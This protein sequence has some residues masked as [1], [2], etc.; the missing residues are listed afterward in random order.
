MSFTHNRLCV[1]LIHCGNK[2]IA[3]PGESWEKN[4]FYLPM[5][6]FPMAAVLKGKGIDVEIISMDLEGGSIED[7]L[8][9]STLDA[10]GMDCHWVNQSSAVLDL[11]ALIKKIKPGVFIFLGGYSASFFSHEIL[12]NYSAVDA[13]IKGDGEVPIAELCDVL[14]KRTQGA[15]NLDN[16]RNLSWKNDRGEIVSNDISYVAAPEQ[17][18]TLDFAEISLLRNWKYYRDLSKFWTK[19]TPLDQFPVFFL[20][21][22]R[23][24]CYNC[25]FCGGNSRAQECIGNRRG[26][27]VRSIDSVIATIEKAVSYGYGMIYHSLEFEGSDRWYSELFRRIKKENIVK[28]HAYGCWGVPSKFLIDELSEC[29]E[30]AIIEVSPETA[31]LELR[32]KNKDRRI[33]YSNE[34]LEECLDYIKTKPNVKI[35]L[36]FG[37]FLPFETEESVFTTLNYI[38]TLL[39]KY[40][41]VAEVIYS[42]LSTDPASLLFLDPGKYDVAISVRCIGDYIDALKENNIERIKESQSNLTLFRPAGIPHDEAVHLAKKIEFFKRTFSLFHHSALLILNK[43]ARANVICDYL[44]TAD[45]SGTPISQFTPARIRDVLSDICNTY[46]IRS[47]ELR[48]VIYD[49]YKNGVD[50]NVNLTIKGDTGETGTVTEEEKNRVRRSIRQARGNIEADFDI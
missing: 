32:K 43:A 33:C 9:F 8:D 45:L 31:D 6:L 14:R 27:A 26:F 23:G 49:E 30:H 2:N 28:N 19:F 40:S 12:T 46:N 17:L 50:V 13:V 10:V 16:V 47:A 41:S 29:F 5:G 37:Y 25:S 3:A 24:C 15:S 22:G 42:N 44:R 11:A 39:R 4:C 1:K 38:S 20:E 48:Q 34:E 21:V 18:D 35:Q 7:V 36:Y